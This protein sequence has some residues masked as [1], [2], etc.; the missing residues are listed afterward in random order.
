MRLLCV[1]YLVTSWARKILFFYFFYE[2]A[3]HVLI[4]S[5]NYPRSLFRDSVFLLDLCLNFCEPVQL[6]M[7]PETTCS[8]RWLRESLLFVV[9]V[10]AGLGVVLWSLVP[11]CL[12]CG[13]WVWQQQITFITCLSCNVILFHCWYTVYLFNDNVF[14]ISISSKNGTQY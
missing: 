11:G 2:W 4:W 10:N 9:V 8:S 1:Y 5:L 6:T 7:W 13:S 12:T 14:E 3:D